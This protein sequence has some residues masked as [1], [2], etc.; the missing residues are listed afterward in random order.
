M[1]MLV[2]QAGVVLV[3]SLEELAD[4]LDLAF[5]CG[6]IQ[7][8]SAI[9][10]ESGA[11]KALTLDLAEEIGLDLPEPGA[12]T[13]AALREVLPDFIPVSNPD[14]LDRAGLGRSRPLP[15]H[16]GAIVGR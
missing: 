8:G 3:D 12:A 6:H 1:K 7:G 14:G 15:A 4:T 5:R 2:T 13:T 16:A 11:F 10:T 9:L